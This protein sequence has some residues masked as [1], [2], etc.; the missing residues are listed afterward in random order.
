MAGEHF[1]SRLLY[2]AGAKATHVKLQRAAV[3]TLSS[4]IAMC[5]SNQRIM[6]EE[7]TSEWLVEF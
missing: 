3:E 1:S 7:L 5:P 6:V 4:L 2:L